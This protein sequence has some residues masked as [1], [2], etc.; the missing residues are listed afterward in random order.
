MMKIDDIDP[1]TAIDGLLEQTFKDIG[2]PARPEIIDRISAEMIKV[3]PNFRQLGQIISGDVGLSASLMKTANSP[4]F[5]LNRKSYSPLEALMM[6]G[7]DVA[8][9]AIA[10]ICL[11]N[12]YLP[13]RE[14]EIL[15]RRSAQVAALSGWLAKSLGGRKLRADMAYTYGLFRDCG[16]PVMLKRFPGYAAVL[17]RANGDPLLPY[18]Q[19]EH[20]G[21][22]DFPID[23]A[24]V[25]FLL[26]KDWWLPE[27]IS[28]AIRHHHEL[29][30]LA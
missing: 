19:V 18:T 1:V 23:H 20:F 8:S 30:A 6:L 29:A 15:L 13:N 22:P 25:G 12:V 11:R 7:L 3:D 5:G 4:F 24:L 2:I 21:L 26:A 9:Q 14:T 27:E 17:D 10:G 28:I 16:V